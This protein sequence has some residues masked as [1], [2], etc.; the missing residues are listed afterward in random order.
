[1]ET[2]GGGAAVEA[3]LKGAAVEAALEKFW[4]MSEPEG[5]KAGKCSELSGSEEATLW[6]ELLEL[7]K[8]LLE[9]LCKGEGGGAVPYRMKE[10][11]LGL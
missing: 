1:M 6:P 7:A 5:K 4:E 8:I 11:V 2:P 9:L 10:F 3:A